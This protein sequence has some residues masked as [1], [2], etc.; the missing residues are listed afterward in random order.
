[1]TAWLDLHD[2]SVTAW[3]WNPWGGNNTLIQN[4]QSYA[5]TVGFGQAYHDWTANHD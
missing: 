2:Y 3:T 1:M 5:P 4:A